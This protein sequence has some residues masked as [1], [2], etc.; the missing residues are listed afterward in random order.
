[1]MMRILSLGLCA[2]VAAGSF[3]TGVLAQAVDTRCIR[4]G[5]PALCVEPEIA[6]LDLDS[7]YD[8]EMWVYGLCD[9]RGPYLWRSRAWCEARGGTY[10]ADGVCLNIQPL[11]D[12]DIVPVSRAF[13]VKVHSACSIGWA[14]TGWGHTIPSNILCWTGGPAYQNGKLIRDFRTLD[15]AGLATS[16]TGCDASWTETVQ[17]GKWRRLVCPM[18]YNQRTKANGDIE[19]WKLPVECKKIGNPVNLL[20]GC[21]MQDE[22][23]YR[24]RTPGGIGL[25][26]YY[27]SGGY[28]RFDAAPVRA[29]DVWRTNWDRR[30]LVP[31][32]ATTVMAYAQRPEGAVL[33]FLP[34]G[35]EM[36]NITGGSSATLEPPSSGSAVW[37][38]TTAERDVELYDGAGRLQSVTSRTGLTHTLAY[39][40]G[41]RLS[42]ARPWPT[43][44]TSAVIA[45]RRSTSSVTGRAVPS[46]TTE[47]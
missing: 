17:A 41:G 36:H 47:R 22:I 37:K 16:Y 15:F 8:S 34:S 19:C 4:D 25:E 21:K 13:E 35:K 26:R 7:F 14:D 2:I 32:V 31:P 9:M 1:M 5:G 30:I 29:T 33:A 42:A 11:Y 40:V 20:D 38:L 28:F 45:I 27:N 39:D 46:T 3:A 44:S 6:P 43:F 12:P 10:G 18:G 24:S 23:D